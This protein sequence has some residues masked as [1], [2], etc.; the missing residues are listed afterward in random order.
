MSVKVLKIA[1]SPISVD[2]KSVYLY[3]HKLVKNGW[4]IDFAYLTFQRVHFLPPL[5]LFV[6]TSTRLMYILRT[7]NYTFTNARYFITVL[8][9]MLEDPL[10]AYI[11][12]K[13][14]SF[15]FGEFLWE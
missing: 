4:F 11:S 6:C 13:K 7:S 1:N 2:W 8:G 3:V 15:N 14:L 5:L 9:D 10:Y 12:N